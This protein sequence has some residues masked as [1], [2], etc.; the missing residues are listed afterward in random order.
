M[1]VFNLIKLVLMFAVF[2]AFLTIDTPGQTGFFRT[3]TGKTPTVRHSKIELDKAGN[4]NLTPCAGKSLLFNG[5]LLSNSFVAL[6]G[7]TASTQSFAAGAAD[8]AGIASA[9]A[10]HTINFPI[11][12]V[13][14]TARTGTIPI[15]TGQNSL[16]K[17][18]ISQSAN[19]L[20]FT[21]S[22][23][24]TINTD[25]FFVAAPSV[26]VLDTQNLQAGDV[27]GLGNNTFLVIDDSTSLLQSRAVNG[28]QHGGAFSATGNV[29]AN[30]FATSCTGSSSVTGNTGT[31][32]T[33]C[34]FDSSDKIFLQPKTAAAGVYQLI[35]TANAA[36]NFTVSCVGD[37]AGVKTF[38]WFVVRAQS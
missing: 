17:S 28:W 11:T 32:A 2:G 38:D 18:F 20:L 13:T 4:V 37:C 26:I 35:K 10:T 8:A 6:N 1:K 24:A 5:Q 30:K 34:V 25:R 31:V 15:F 9:G 23:S 36:G 27:E 29:S 12:S 19:T 33:P 22:S 21:P 14:G 7:L 3:C 16:G